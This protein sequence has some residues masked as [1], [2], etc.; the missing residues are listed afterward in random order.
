MK[1]LIIIITLLMSVPCI[2]QNYNVEKDKYINSVLCQKP[3]KVLKIDYT[4]AIYYELWYDEIKIEWH[5]YHQVPF[6]QQV[7]ECFLVHDKSGN[8]IIID[9]LVNKHR[10]SPNTLIRIK[11]ICLNIK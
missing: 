3:N 1:T 8:I 4:N 11:T 5:L 10:I 7:S 6:E 9:G 2:A